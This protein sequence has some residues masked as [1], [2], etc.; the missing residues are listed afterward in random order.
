MLPYGSS[1]VMFVAHVV[2]TVGMA[3]T[4]GAVALLLFA[5]GKLGKLICDRHRCV[6]V[7]YKE[8][9]RIAFITSTSSSSAVHS[10]HP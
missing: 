3:A 10:L 9:C 8:S 6:A 7:L 1:A 2:I 4:A 5:S